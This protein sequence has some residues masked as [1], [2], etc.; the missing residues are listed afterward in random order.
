[1]NKECDLA[2]A[3]R[4]A[5]TAKRSL[6]PQGVETISLRTGAVLVVED[7][8]PLCLQARIMASSILIPYLLEKSFFPGIAAYQGPPRFARWPDRRNRSAVRPDCD[9]RSI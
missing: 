5:E 9:I 1:M 2:C 8:E 3:I 6:P 4:E 7:E